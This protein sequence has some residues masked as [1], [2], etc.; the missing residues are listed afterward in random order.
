M[1]IWCQ[2][3]QMYRFFFSHTVVIFHGFP[4]CMSPHMPP[5]VCLGKPFSKWNRRMWLIDCSGRCC[6]AISC[7]ADTKTPTLKVLCCLMFL[8]CPCHCAEVLRSLTENVRKLPFY[9][10]LLRSSS[11]ALQATSHALLRNYSFCILAADREEGL[12]VV[13]YWR[14]ARQILLSDRGCF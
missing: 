13:L 11:I 1:N 8:L 10:K 6:F 3:M 7:R 12:V 4:R 9:N 14:L 2:D 5:R